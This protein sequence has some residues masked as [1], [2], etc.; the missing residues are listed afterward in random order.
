MN[1]NDVRIGLRVTTTPNLEEPIGMM[2]AYKHLDARKP[3]IRGTVIQVIPGHGGDCW[4]VL[5]EDGTCGAYC[6]NE[7]EKDA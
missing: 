7:F 1:C 4:F 5:H 3:G 2:V 6:F